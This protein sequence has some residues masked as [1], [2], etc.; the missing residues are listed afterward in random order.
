[1]SKLYDL[2]DQYTNS[3]CILALILLCSCTDVKS[4]EHAIKKEGL[5]PVTVGGIWFHANNV[6]LNEE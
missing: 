3:F 2:I 1:M 6:I 4:A 5:V